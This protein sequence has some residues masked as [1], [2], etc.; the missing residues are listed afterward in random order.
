[1]PTD[2]RNTIEVLRAE[3]DFIK[4]GGYASPAQDP[5]RTKLGLEDSPTCINCN[6]KENPVPCSECLLIQ[7]VPV[8][9]RGERVPCRHIPLTPDGD[10]LLHLYHGATEEEVDKVLAGWL[11]ETISRLELTGNSRQQPAE[12]H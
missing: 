12:T 10:T 7:F 1:M 11:Q 3:L 2:K 5:W 9:K 6:R 8:N 4:K